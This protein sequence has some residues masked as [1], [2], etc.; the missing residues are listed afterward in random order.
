MISYDR[1]RRMLAVPDSDDV[2]GFVWARL[3]YI[4]ATL[5]EA[6]LDAKGHPISYE[7]LLKSY[8]Y[9]VKDEANLAALR[10]NIYHLRQRGVPIANVTGYGYFLDDEA[11][12]CPTC[13]RVQ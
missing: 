2:E 11:L 5:L 3:G 8:G 7:D 4:Q 10:A 1:P 6:L 9:E 12:R 13:G